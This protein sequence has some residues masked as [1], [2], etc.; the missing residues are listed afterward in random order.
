MV[1]EQPTLDA[2]S[3]NLPQ[4]FSLDAEELTSMLTDMGVI[5]TGSDD[6][7]EPPPQ[8]ERVAPHAQMQQVEREIDRGERDADTGKR[9]A[10]EAKITEGQARHFVDVANERL[11]KA[12]ETMVTVQNTLKAR[13]ADLSAE[14][15][16]W[17]QLFRP[18]QQTR[19]QLM[20]EHLA[21]NLQHK[22]DV[23]A[24][25]IAP[26]RRA[27]KGKSYIDQTSGRGGDANDFARRY[28][29]EHSGLG[30]A[31]V[32]KGAHRN[33]YP[34]QYQNRRVKLPSEA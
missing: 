22:M 2:V 29:G 19:E 1:H 11:S 25:K 32:S 16:G 20:R 4:D 6:G 24:G 14:I 34:S 7:D 31:P 9:I 30:G 17:Q 27:G 13:R 10:P 15:L 33:A 3:K 18:L 8:V 28:T 26:P 21:A 5:K 12:R 23:K